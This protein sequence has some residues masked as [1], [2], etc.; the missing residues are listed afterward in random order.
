MLFLRLFSTLACESSFPLL[1]SFANVYKCSS[2][3][4]HVPV[5]SKIF[6]YLT[7]GL[8]ILTKIL[9]VPR[10]SV[11]AEYCSWP[12]SHS[13]DFAGVLTSVYVLFFFVFDNIRYLSTIR[14]PPPTHPH[15]PAIARRLPPGRPPALL[16]TRTVQHEATPISR[17][18]R[19]IRVLPRM[20]FY[21]L[22]F[23]HFVEYD[24][25]LCPVRLFALFANNILALFVFRS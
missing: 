23:P 3:C 17:I 2:P 8:A 25:Q 24:Y 13:P 22:P 4:T 15:H 19:G 7:N 11:F 14:Q 12:F 1:N 16:R 18:L 9:Y 6:T 5:V 20:H 21:L 10:A